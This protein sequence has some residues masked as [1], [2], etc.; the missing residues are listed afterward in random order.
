MSIIETDTIKQT[1]ELITDTISTG[2]DALPFDVSDLPDVSDVSDT[3]SHAASVA[4][5]KSGKGAVRVY[6][7]V[8][9]TV[10]KHPRGAGL[11]LVALV[12]L[13]GFVVWWGRRSATDDDSALHVAQ[14]A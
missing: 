2:I 4:A 8:S 6:R 3:V 10:R 1:K 5:V 9:K 14:A 11:S 7:T 12:A 13:V